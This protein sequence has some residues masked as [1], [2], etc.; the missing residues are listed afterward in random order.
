MCI[1]I[2]CSIVMGAFLPALMT[3]MGK[4]TNVFINY[5]FMKTISESAAND[6]T[7][8]ITFICSITDEKEFYEELDGIFRAK[9]KNTTL[10]SVYTRLNMDEHEFI[11][12]INQTLCLNATTFVEI[13]KSDAAK[14]SGFMGMTGVLTFICSY[15]MVACLSSSAYNQAHRIKMK[16]FRSVLHQDIT[17]FDT[18]TSGDFATKINRLKLFHVLISYKIL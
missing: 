4:M 14:F 10:K 16:F 1:G 13:F 6:T 8:M 2:L 17:W 5:E 11:H 3:L 9:F 15:V 18:K 12:Q 7:G